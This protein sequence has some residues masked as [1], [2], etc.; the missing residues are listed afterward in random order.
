MAH[1]P[2]LLWLFAGHSTVCPCPAC[3]GETKTRHSPP[4]VSHQCWAEG[5]DHVPCPVGNTFP[6]A[7]RDAGGL[8]CSKGTL[9]DPQVFFCRAPCQPLGLCFLLVHEVVP[10]SVQDSIFP[11]FKLR[12]VV[13]RMCRAWHSPLP[14][15]LR[16]LLAPCS[17]LPGCLWK[18]AHA[19]FLLIINPS[20]PGS[21]LSANSPRVQCLI[22]Q[23]IHDVKQV[24]TQ[25]WPLGHNPSGW[26]PTG[27]C[28][29][30]H[31]SLSAAVQ[32]AYPHYLFI[33]PILCQLVWERC[34]RRKCWKPFQSQDKQSPLLSPH[35]PS[36]SPH[37][38]SLSGC[39]DMI[40]PS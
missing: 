19:S 29:A 1:A 40:S 5:K 32:L 18:P 11:V 14:N 13:L 17:S 20:W 33:Y 22:V 35:L 26:T 30:H 28:A 8:L 9:T 12:E 25:R 2:I 36:Q 3:T 21:A 6:N 7:T 37:S 27:L 34:Y 39:S 10:P 38:G 24:W 23:V 31:N 15:F 4:D 16:L